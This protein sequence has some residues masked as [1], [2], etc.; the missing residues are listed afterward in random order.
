MNVT[1]WLKRLAIGVA[2]AAIAI[3]W[4]DSR[5]AMFRVNHNPA[6]PIF[7][8]TFSLF[9]T[10]AIGLEQ[11]RIGEVDLDEFTRYSMLNDPYAPY[12]RP[13][14]GVAPHWVPYYTLDIGYSFIVEASRLLFPQL[15]DNQLRAI[16]LQIVADMALVCFVAFVFCQWDLWMGLLAAYLYSSNMVFAQ[17]SSIAFYYYWDIPLAFLVL[18]SIL[19]ALQRTTESTLWLATAGATL[20]FGV[21]LRGSWWPLSLLFFGV[22]ASSPALRKNLTAAIV[23]FLILATPQVIRSSIARGHL[24]FT[25]RTVWHVAMVGL[26]YYPNAY[27]LSLHDEDI[28]RLTK[29]KYG[30]NH[31]MEDYEAHDLAAQKEFMAMWEQNRAFVL[32]SF[33]GRL[34]ESLAGETE[35]S[36]PSFRFFKNRSYRLLCLAGFVAMLFRGREKRLMALAAAGAYVV[37]V[38]LTSAFFYVSLAYDTVSQVTLFILFIGGLEAALFATAWTLRCHDDDPA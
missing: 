20:G 38:L 5:S 10:M 35:S 30:V 21:W 28:F 23:A 11:G 3:Q 25:T 9:H 6:H 12:D 7:M 26:G 24:T 22:A 13:D 2:I 37:Y 34:S 19:L 8:S 15:P 27:G 29:D 31:R 16:A 33:A 1:L 14:T 32:R 17:H 4:V 18:G 36:S